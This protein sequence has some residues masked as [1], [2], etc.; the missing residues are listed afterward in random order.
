[1]IN[2]NGFTNENKINHN[3]KWLFFPDH[4]YKIL[5]IGGSGSEKTSFLLNL[6]NYQQ[7]IYKIYLYAKDLYQAIYQFLINKPENVGLKHC[8]DCNAFI[9]CSIGKVSINILKNTTQVKN[10]KNESFFMICFLICLVKKNLS[11]GNWI[12]Y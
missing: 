1:M 12:T 5:I 3:P 10:V 9:E 4:W 2:F 8:N 6:I 7:D 11:N